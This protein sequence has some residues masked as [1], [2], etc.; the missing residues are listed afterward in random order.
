M[1]TC[2]ANTK[3]NWTTNKE[4]LTVAQTQPRTYSK[5]G[6]IQI[7]FS[8]SLLQPGAGGFFPVN[9]EQ[10]QWAERREEQGKREAEAVKSQNKV[11]LHIKQKKEDNTR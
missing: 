5:L 6:Q 7:P 2:C 9:R 11:L 8:I 1:R 4:I 10:L 3:I